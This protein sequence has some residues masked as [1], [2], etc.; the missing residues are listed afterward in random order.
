[1]ILA[2]VNLLVYAFDS[3]CAEHQRY[4]P[5]LSGVLSSQ[6][7]LALADPVLAGFLRLVTNPKIMPR[8]APAAVAMSFVEV[9]L[10]AEVTR[11]LPINEAVWTTLGS[12]IRADPGI[13]GNVVPDA[14]LAALAVTNGA[15]L[16]TADRGFTR[17]PGLRSYDPA[18]VE[19]AQPPGRGRKPR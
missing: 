4:R 8:P 10:E 18:E 7:E 14:Y 1:M 12:W 6:E 5:W 17:F 3:D 9:L 11:W 2:D 13:R 15:R 16:G 19:R